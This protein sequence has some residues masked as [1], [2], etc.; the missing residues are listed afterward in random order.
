MELREIEVS[1]KKDA[2][3]VEGDKIN[4]SDQVAELLRDYYGSEI[5]FVEKFFAV[6]L[7]R[8][9]QPLGIKMISQGG[10]SET[11]VDPKVIFSIALKVNA[12]AII[13]SHNHPSGSLKPSFADN[14]MT[15]QI[16]KAGQLLE[17]DVLDHLIITENSHFSYADNG[18]F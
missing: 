11:V 6:F 17:I 15:D 7:N 1:Y 18:M 8:Q 4:N 3:V 9:N 10:F 14:K 13:I 12:S 5:T 2:K 16:K